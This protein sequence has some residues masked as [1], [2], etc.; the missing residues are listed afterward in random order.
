MLP[1]KY[2]I[3]ALFAEGSFEKVIKSIN[4]FS[5]KENIVFIDGLKFGDI[6]FGL[7]AFY[8]GWINGGQTHTWNPEKFNIPVSEGKAAVCMFKSDSTWFLQLARNTGIKEQT[9]TKVSHINQIAETIKD[10]WKK[11]FDITNMCSD[12][13]SI[14]MVCSKGLDLVQSYYICKDIPY[15]FIKKKV[16]VGQVLID[17][18]DIGTSYVWLFSANTAYNEMHFVIDPDYDKVVDIKDNIITTEG[19]N[20]YSLSFI[21]IINGQLLFVFHK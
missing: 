6:H 12:N 16:K 4:R 15:G 13:E 21:R 5:K 17:I 8:T 19:Y 9:I 10:Q 2:D 11:G 20:G 14:Y 7:A 3:Q 1:N 18:L